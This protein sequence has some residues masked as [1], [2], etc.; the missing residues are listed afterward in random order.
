VVFSWG[1]EASYNGVNGLTT[2]GADK[3]ILWRQVTLGV[4]VGV[5][6]V[7]ELLLRLTL[8]TVRVAVQIKGV[9]PKLVGYNGGWEC[10]VI[11]IFVEAQEGMFAVDF[12]VTNNVSSVHLRRAKANLGNWWHLLAS[13]V[14]GLQSK[15]IW[16]GTCPKIEGRRVQK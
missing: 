2:I 10:W 14:I 1:A 16:V 15:G 8:G 7:A 3:D 11:C 13:A 9:Y 12:V 6:E 5:A 4:N